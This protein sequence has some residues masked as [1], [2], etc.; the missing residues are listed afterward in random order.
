MASTANKTAAQVNRSQLMTCADG[1]WRVRSQE[2][3][4]TS[5]LLG[6]EWGWE[7]GWGG[8]QVVVKD[9]RHYVTPQVP[10]VICHYIV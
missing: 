3:A 2:T 6:R 1:E 7:V 5:A 9:G 4:D 10:C 8:G